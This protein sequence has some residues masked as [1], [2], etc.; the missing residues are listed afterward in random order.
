MSVVPSVDPASMTMTSAV[1]PSLLV[2]S[3]SS[4]SNSSRLARSFQAGIKIVS[5]GE[6]AVACDTDIDHTVNRL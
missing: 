3:P 5:C 4:G 1:T 6:P 2:T